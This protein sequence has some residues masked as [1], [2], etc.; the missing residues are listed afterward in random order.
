MDYILIKSE[1]TD[2]SLNLLPWLIKC[3]IHCSQPNV[4]Q[5]ICLTSSYLGNENE[6]LKVRREL[7]LT[8]YDEI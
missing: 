6:K 4:C 3:L 1:D 2:L 7:I 5:L 8:K